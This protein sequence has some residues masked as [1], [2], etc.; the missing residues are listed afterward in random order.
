MKLENNLTGLNFSKYFYISLVNICL[1]TSQASKPCK[2]L[3]SL[4]KLITNSSSLNKG[5]HDR[6]GAWISDPN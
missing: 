4:L 5:N 2:E 1:Q 3:C 6:D